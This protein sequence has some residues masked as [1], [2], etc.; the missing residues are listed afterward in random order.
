MNTSSYNN[1]PSLKLA[2]IEEMREHIEADRL[3]KGTYGRGDKL[4]EDFRGCS[5]ACSIVSLNKL[6][7]KKIRTNDHSGLADA[8]GLPECGW[9][10]RLQD[11][12]FERL[13]APEHQ[14]WSLDFLDAIP[15]GVSVEKIQ[16]VRWKFLTPVLTDTMDLDSLPE[17]VQ[18]AVARVRGLCA[19]AGAGD[20][21]T[22]DEWDAAA[23]EATARAAADAADAAYAA[24]AAYAA[25]DAARAAR[26][27]ADAA[28]AAADA[29]AYAASA[30]TAAAYATVAAAYAASAT[31]AAAYATV[32]AARRKW[33]NNLLNLLRKA[34]E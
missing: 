31:T 4:L 2:L 9:L 34:G 16:L 18:S 1:D 3:I 29:A 13:P 12:F 10:T 6:M 24:R 5:V 17:N 7:G 21:P 33:A 27:A 30:T 15:V 19:R 25:S 20:M 28:R 23:A 26:A 14:Q 8:I 32:A 11:H 22:S